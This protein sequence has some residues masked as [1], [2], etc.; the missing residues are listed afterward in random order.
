[1]LFKTFKS[2]KLQ[3]FFCITGV[4]T[5][6]FNEHWSSLDVSKIADET[7]VVP[8]ISSFTLIESVTASYNTIRGTTHHHRTLWSIDEGISQTIELTDECTAVS[9]AITDTTEHDQC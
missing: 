2:F 5:L 4:Y 3:N 9:S 7:A 1:L 6:C 8:S